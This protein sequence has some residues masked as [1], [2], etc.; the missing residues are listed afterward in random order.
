MKKRGLTAFLTHALTDKRRDNRHI[1]F[2]ILLRLAAAA[3]LKRKTSLTAVPFAVTEA[4]L[5]TKSQ[6]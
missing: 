5:L 2:D 1:P 4:E 3:R 6:Q